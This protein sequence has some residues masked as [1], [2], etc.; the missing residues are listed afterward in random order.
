MK[1]AIF[2]IAFLALLFCAAAQNSDLDLENLKGQKLAT[3]T[4]SVWS[5][6]GF[7]RVSGIPARTN[8]FIWSMG[9]NASL[10]LPGVSVP[11][12]FT[13]GQYGNAF[14][15]PVFGQFGISPK[16][17]SLTGHFG[18]RNL[19]FSNY[20]LNGHT[21]LGAGLE[22]NHK[23]LRFAAMHGRLRNATATQPGL[24]SLLPTFGRAGA[25][26]K[27]GFGDQKSFVDFIAFKAKDK[28][29]TLPQAE[30]LG[31]TPAE[32]LVLGTNMRMQFFP[33]LAGTLEVAGSAFTRN[34]NSVALDKNDRTNVEEFLP[35][36]LFNSNASTRFNMAFKAGLQYASERFRMGLEYERIDPEYETMGAF[37]FLNDFKN[38]LV[39]PGLSLFKSTLNLAGSLGLQQ[40][41]VLGN[42]SET[43]R[44]FIGNGTLSYAAAGKPF[45]MSL[46]YSNFTINQADGTVELS[47]TIR[48][49]LVT[50]NVNFTPYFNWTRDTSQTRSLVFSANYQQLNDRNP[51][52]REFSDMTTLF[53]TGTYSTFFAG[54]ALG[55]NFGANYNQIEVF[56]LDTE[57]YG[58][59]AGLSKNLAEGKLN[60]SAN[61]TYNLTRVNAAHDGANWSLNVSAGA[62]AGKKLFISLYANVLANNSVLFDDYVEW[63][64]GLQLNYRVRP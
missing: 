27:L 60:A 7:Y 58:L 5:Q 18:H 45:G 56:G 20:T 51:F 30:A 10:N 31:V 63:M 25:G 46:H 19:V 26:I 49:S 37:F 47:D 33:R 36:A 52:T 35:R 57:R 64:G 41:N 14:H 6:T 21:F 8:N 16:Y 40:N 38:Y 22:V 9:A 1:T 11:F 4:G 55:F 48:L 12:A 61:G 17:K 24:I 29:S 28:A 23:K 32:N 54:P 59:S 44:R 42:R 2:T 39:T 3:L 53:F 43:T 62:T 34:Q 13:L 50:T 15:R